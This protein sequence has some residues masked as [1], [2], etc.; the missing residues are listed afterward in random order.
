MEFLTRQEAAN[1]L[2]IGLRTLDR[3]LASGELAHYKIG[4]GPRALVRISDEQIIEYLKQTA[5]S[6]TAMRRKQVRKIMNR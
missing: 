1:K 2:R 6:S 3:R 5:L 4:A